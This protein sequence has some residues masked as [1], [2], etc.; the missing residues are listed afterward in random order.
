NFPTVNPL[1]SGNALRGSD[2]AFVTEFNP[3]SGPL[4]STYLGGTSDDSAQAVAVD[5]QG[6]AY[7]TGWTQS[8]DFPTANPILNKSPG[9]DAFVTK[10]FVGLAAPTITGI[11]PDSGVSANDQITN[12]QNLQILGT[13]PPGSTVTVSRADVGAL[14]NPV[15][16][17]SNGNW[18]YDYR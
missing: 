8:T 16:A 15:T 5:L 3:T 18:T 10:I 13:A 14:P 12:V 7:V 9:K 1:P 2:D 6:N 17:N 4:F 11:S